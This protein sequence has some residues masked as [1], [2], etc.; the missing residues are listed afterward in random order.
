MTRG[1]KI[2]IPAKL[3]RLKNLRMKIQHFLE[4]YTI[5]EEDVFTLLLMIDEILT[6]IPSNTAM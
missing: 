2:S 6:Q 1:M 5:K 4:R 3:S